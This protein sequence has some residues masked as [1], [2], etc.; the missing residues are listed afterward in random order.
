M[1]KCDFCPLWRAASVPP[2]IGTK[3]TLCQ[4]NKADKNNFSKDVLPKANPL[5]AKNLG[6][7][8]TS[9]PF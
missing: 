7:S 6:K 8:N 2:V 9:V 1:P 5:G 4:S 3:L